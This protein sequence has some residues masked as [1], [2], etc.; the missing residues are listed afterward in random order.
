[1]LQCFT[2]IFHTTWRVNRIKEQCLTIA[3]QWKKS[4][5]P[6]AG[7]RRAADDTQ[8]KTCLNMDIELPTSNDSLDGFYEC[9]KAGLT[10]EA[11]LSRYEAVFEFVHSRGLTEDYRL[12]RRQVKKLRDEVTP[13]A[14]FCAK[15]VE[16]QDTIRFNLD[17][18][19]P[20]CVLTRLNKEIC[21]IEVTVAQARERH[22]L[23]TE[24]HK[25]GSGRGFI[26]VADD[27]PKERFDEM[28]ALES[29]AYSTEEAIQCIEYAIGLCSERKKF[30]S[31]DVILIETPFEILPAPRWL[32][33]SAEFAER[34]EGV[35]FR[36]VYLT[37]RGDDGDMVLKIK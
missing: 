4:R 34:V 7:L 33:F 21:E 36:E 29:R 1:M 23:M 11:F 6:G 5:L 32:E 22:A 31:G 26:G 20:D 16:P 35:R 2:L 14:R 15:C 8:W 24:L 28:M 19:Y 30:H 12:G 9:L 37:G 27:Q 17:E 3:S 25:T 13:V 10:V 18:K